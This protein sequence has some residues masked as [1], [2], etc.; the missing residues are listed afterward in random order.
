[1]WVGSVLHL[2]LLLSIEF[3]PAIGLLLSPAPLRQR[4]CDYSPFCILQ[5]VAGGLPRWSGLAVSTCDAYS[6]AW[7][8]KI[9]VC[10]RAITHEC[11]ST[12]QVTWRERCS[13]SHSFWP[14]LWHSSYWRSTWISN[15]AHSCVSWKLDFQ[16]WAVNVTGNKTAHLYQS[17]WGNIRQ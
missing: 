11:L 6:V 15:W 14:S 8:H 13:S 10:V 7:D 16:A 9:K 3:S 4:I 5:V 17:L 1:M 12:P 2:K